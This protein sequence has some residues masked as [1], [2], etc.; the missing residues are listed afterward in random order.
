MKN[1]DSF[2]LRKHLSVGM[3]A[4][5]LRDVCHTLRLDHLHRLSAH[6]L[7]STLTLLGSM[8][9][10]IS[11]GSL[12][13]PPTCS[14]FPVHLETAW[15]YPNDEWHTLKGIVH[16]LKLAY[17]Q[18]KILSELYLLRLAFTWQC[19]HY[20]YVSQHPPLPNTRD[21]LKVVACH[22]SNRVDVQACQKFHS[23][24]TQGF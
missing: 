5:T 8:M 1:K 22:E 6:F 23:L 21:I 18:L 19:H 20:Y 12:L 17:F 10:V 24:N 15:G 2:K 13:P 16:L 9:G 14:T 11:L 4:A 3:L 7:P